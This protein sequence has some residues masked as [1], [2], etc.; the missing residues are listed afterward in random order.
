[1]AAPPVSI[2]R[3]GDLLCDRFRV[4][5][6]IAR[7]GMGELYEAEDT[8]LGEHV[9]LKTIRPEIAADERANQR[10]KRE[11]QLARKVTHPHICRIFDLFHHVPSASRGSAT[12]AV[13]VTMELLAG[14]TLSEHL[15]RIG[16]MSTEQALPIIV[17]MAAALSAAHEVGIV[18]RDFKSSN[19][20]R[21]TPEEPGKPSRVVV[22]DFGLANKV[23]KHPDASISTMTQ[24]GELLGTPDYMAPEQLDGSAVTP[25]A[26]L[27]ALGIVIYEMVTGAR[28]FA[29][30]TPLASAM[31]RISGPPATPPREIVRDLPP[32]WNDVIMRCLARQ[33]ADRFPNSASIV[34]ALTGHAPA[35]A[36]AWPAS[37]VVLSAVAAIVVAGAAG[38][39]WREFTAR[40]GHADGA[41]SVSASVAPV[42]PR[43][44]IAV[45]GFRNLTG[46]DDT[47][48]LSVA[49]SEML[50]TELAAGERLRTVSGENIS[51]VKADLGLADADAYSADTLARIQ[52]NL[53]T[54]LV[55]LG[56]YVVVGNG[57]GATLRLDV[58]LQ[59]ST[60][61]ETLSVVSESGKSA[62]LFDVISRAGGRLRERL[63]VEA[64][65]EATASVRSTLPAS[66]EASRLYS[67]GLLRL[68]RLDPL[69]AR[70]LLEKSIA[71]DPAFPLAHTALAEA[72]S[73]LGYDE[74]ARDSAK[75]AFELSS[76]LGRADR[77]QVE[78]TYHEASN[79]WPEAIGIWRSLSTFFPDDVEYVLKLSNAQTESGAAKDG[80]ATIEDFRKRLPDVKDPR[81]NLEE[82]S[83][84][85]TLSDF[86]R[87]QAA[88]AAAATAGERLGAR[89]L[90]ADAR[91][92]EGG[93]LLRM[94]QADSAATMFEEA[95]RTYDEANDRAGVARSLNNLATSLSDGPQTARVVKLYEDGLKIARTIGDQALI[96][97][98]LNNLAVQERRAGNLESSLRLNQESLAIRNEIGDPTNAAISVNNIGNVLL[99]LGDHR[100]ASQ[101]Y[102][103][104]AAMSRKLGDRR[105]EARALHNAG[106]AL[107]L[108]GEMA[109]ARA[110]SE[111][112]LKIRR[113]IDDPASV[114]TS[115]YGVGTIAALQGDFA[116]ARHTLNEALDMDRRLNRRRPMAYDLFALGDMALQRGDLDAAR[117][118]FQESLTV[119]TEL[120]E[121]GTAAESRHALA[122]LALEEGRPSDADAPL[123]DAVAVF[124]AQKAPE[125]E[126]AARTALAAA[127]L[128]QNRR[129]DAEREI[130]RARGLSR[131]TQS[132]V[133]RLD[134]AIAGARIEAASNADAALKSLEASRA[135]AV[136]RGIP[137]FEFQARRAIVEIE[138][139]RN[140][141]VGTKL[142]EE[143][144]RDAK[145]RGYGL[146]ARDLK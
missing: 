100:G 144:I 126:A 50:T 10:F 79:A 25:A 103:Q 54:D 9:A 33:P 139:R 6:F 136:T 78:G 73:A 91:L 124:A 47:E 30:D 83:A 109:R 70:D 26:D 134:V 7:G 137:K 63:G 51:R 76:N 117:R 97:R 125:N 112:A 59:D 129:A 143:L 114:A 15:K 92:L 64:A 11:V 120:G 34:A 60:E 135:E 80:M 85:E 115:L 27:Y 74:R 77:L 65:P 98:F 36:R 41:S 90:I 146:Y 116:S 22:T 106:E 69:A 16:R 28:P 61:G 17:Q 5:R 127:L 99:D 58:R 104:S 101:H 130:G 62:D 72:W 24:A 71:A 19:V 2:F 87:M 52:Q 18:H 128:A 123:R 37:R 23:N 39:A 29:A 118:H 75:R 55:V 138:R 107:R 67:E 43:R 12:S 102:E 132:A 20:M 96:A 49:L 141:Q 105:G 119:R 82:A 89:R 14:E 45:M 31:R 94:G 86:K 21:L 95:R 48:W 13:F 8:E 4:V 3:P 111:E 40:A 46:R 57:D 140:P 121:K 81:L 1:M 68:R 88:A 142:S 131:N 84:A 44:A 113:G 110:S 108:Q 38:L 122:L 133:T 53:G 35:E 145:R 32:R 56:S 66:P 42:T 93:A